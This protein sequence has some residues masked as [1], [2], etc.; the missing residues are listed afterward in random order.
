[1]KILMGGPVS[2][3]VCYFIELGG[4]ESSMYESIVKLASCSVNANGI[5]LFWWWMGELFNISFIFLLGKIYS[6]F[7]DGFLPLNCHTVWYK[8][9]VIE[10]II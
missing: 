9:F 10:C 5:F 7:S 6:Q 2:V 1:M 3:Y 8:G 4:N